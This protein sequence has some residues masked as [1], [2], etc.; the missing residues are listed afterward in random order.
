MSG[1]NMLK[2]LNEYPTYKRAYKRAFKKMLEERH[3]AGLETEWK[4]E[5]EVFNWWLRRQK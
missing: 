5:N 4:D 2:G 3:K 1:T